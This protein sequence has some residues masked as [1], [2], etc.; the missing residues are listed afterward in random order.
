MKLQLYGD[1]NDWVS[2]VL[3]SKVAYNEVLRGKCNNPESAMGC[4][5]LPDHTHLCSRSLRTLQCIQSNS[6]SYLSQTR[7]IR[8]VALFTPWIPLI[9]PKV[10]VAIFIISAVN[11]VSPKQ[12]VS[13]SLRLIERLSVVSS[14]RFFYLF[15]WN[16]QRVGD[17]KCEGLI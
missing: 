2:H 3:E 6:N 10:C 1:F 8:R 17:W 12:F 16:I 5:V 9:L 4:I 13:T 7:R 15:A 11:P 14:Y